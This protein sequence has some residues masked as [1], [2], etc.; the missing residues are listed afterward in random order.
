MARSLHL[1]PKLLTFSLYL[2]QCS[3]PPYLPLVYRQLLGFTSADVGVLA[4]IP[5]FVAVFAGPFLS[6]MADLSGRPKL[7]L[8][9]SNIATSALLWVFVSVKLTFAATCGLIACYAFVSAPIGSLMDVMILN[10]LGDERDL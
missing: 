6:F 5:P 3:A 7:V 9:L 8:A 1:V 2:S 4:C 10:M